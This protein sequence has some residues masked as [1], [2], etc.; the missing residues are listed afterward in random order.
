MSA[1]LKFVVNG[2]AKILLDKYG[3]DLLGNDSKAVEGQVSLH[4]KRCHQST[5]AKS[6][7]RIGE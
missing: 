1:V 2:G 5:H 6:A 3:Q 4:L 7:E